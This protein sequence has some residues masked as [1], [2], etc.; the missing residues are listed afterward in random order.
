MLLIP[1]FQVLAILLQAVN[2][3]PFRRSIEAMLKALIP[4]R[5]NE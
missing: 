5:F 1:A 4:I 2:P 3:L